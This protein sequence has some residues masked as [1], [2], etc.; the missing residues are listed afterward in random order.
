M[1]LGSQEAQTMVRAATMH[2]DTLR[3]ALVGSIGNLAGLGTFQEGNRLQHEIPG[4][5]VS[6]EPGLT[7]R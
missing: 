7:A 4:F 6:P 3:R 1:A 5:A 2:F